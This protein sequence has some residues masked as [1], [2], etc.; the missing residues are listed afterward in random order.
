MALTTAHVGGQK[1]GQ[2][3]L[4]EKH[5]P[6]PSSQEAAAHLQCGGQLVWLGKDWASWSWALTVSTLLA[7]S[8]VHVV[9]MVAAWLHA[10]A[11]GI[12]RKGLRFCSLAAESPLLVIKAD[13]WERKSWRASNLQK[14]F[15]SLLASYSQIAAAKIWLKTA[16]KNFRAWQSRGSHSLLWQESDKVFK[17]SQEFLNIHNNEHLL[18]QTRNTTLCKK[19]EMLSYLQLWVCYLVHSHKF[20]TLFLP[21]PLALGFNFYSHDPLPQHWF[22]AVEGQHTVTLLM[23]K[24]ALQELCCWWQA[25]ILFTNSQICLMG[26]HPFICSW[27]ACHTIVVEIPCLSFKLSCGWGVAGWEAQLFQTVADCSLLANT[28]KA[29]HS[30]TLEKVLDGSFTEVIFLLA[31]SIRLKQTTKCQISEA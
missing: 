13:E 14:L 4:I 20:K 8:W 10:W 2:T 31:F 11:Q 23:E 17:R 6:T 16:A 28:S 26:S 27:K 24:Q 5:L 21:C 19:I 30:M 25:A 29:S 1:P 18:F 15:Q 12:S 7:R 22:N 3:S 9:S